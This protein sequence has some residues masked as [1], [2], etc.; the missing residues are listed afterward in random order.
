M[1]YDINQETKVIIKLIKDKN[2]FNYCCLNNHAMSMVMVQRIN[3]IYRSL[4]CQ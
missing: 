3:N 2:V 4:E 1:L